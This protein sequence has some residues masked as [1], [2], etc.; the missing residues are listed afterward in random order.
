MASKVV[1]FPPPSVA[2]GLL[3]LVSNFPTQIPL[4][5]SS[6]KVKASGVYQLLDCI[7]EL[8]TYLAVPLSFVLVSTNLTSISPGN[9]DTLSI[10]QYYHIESIYSNKKIMINTT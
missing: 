5:S 4:N 7:P 1:V 3:L 10:F 9:I 6:P 2:L 8:T